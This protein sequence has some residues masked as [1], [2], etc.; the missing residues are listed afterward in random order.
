MRF[1]ALLSRLFLQT[2]WSCIKPVRIKEKPAFL[3]LT[4]TTHV[5][6]YLT[7]NTLQRYNANNTNT[8]S[9][10]RPPSWPKCRPIPSLGD[11]RTNTL[12]R[13]RP[14]LIPHIIG[15]SWKC[16]ST[17]ARTGT[18]VYDCLSSQPLAAHIPALHRP[19]CH[20]FG[21]YPRC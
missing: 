17:V 11:I 16:D 13:I 15:W 3:P 10:E 12:R 7:T 5:L 6:T 9:I 14:L 1:L 4:T 19:R 20:Y 18:H 21:S 8:K 2:L